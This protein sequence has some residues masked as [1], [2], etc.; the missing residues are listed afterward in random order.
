MFP[1]LLIIFIFLI[2][3]YFIFYFYNRTK[4]AE[5]REKFKKINYKDPFENFEKIKELKY[6]SFNRLN[7][8]NSFNEYK[9][10]GIYAIYIDIAPSIDLIPLYIGKSK[11]INVR[12]KQHINK[13]K[14]ANNQFDNKL[15][16]EKK[17]YKILNSLNRRNLKIS[18]L[19]F[20]VLEKCSLKALDRR[21]SYWINFYNASILGWNLKN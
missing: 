9:C 11:N 16:L 6:Y 8:A 3:G 2:I 4:E 20:T 18:D 7:R 13:I 5:K 10:A 15:Y 17:Y 1:L 21:E 14:K 19:K 12:W